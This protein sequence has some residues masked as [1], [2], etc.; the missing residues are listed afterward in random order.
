MPVEKS[1][2]LLCFLIVLNG[3]DPGDVCKQAVQLVKVSG[4]PVF[5]LSSVYA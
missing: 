2:C 4:G 5:R 3:G 1:E